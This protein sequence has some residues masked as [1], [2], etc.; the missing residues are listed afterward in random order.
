VRF[1]SVGVV[2]DIVYRPPLTHDLQEL[3]KLDYHSGNSHRDRL[4]G[5]T[6]TGIG[7]WT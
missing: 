4:S 3:R 1:L 2:K 5:E 7:L 6:M